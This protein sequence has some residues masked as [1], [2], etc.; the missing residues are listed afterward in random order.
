MVLV[1]LDI[2][3]RYQRVVFSVCL[4]VLRN[5]EDAEDIMQEVFVK[6]HKH[7]HSIRDENAIKA[8]LVHTAYNTAL[9]SL[10]YKP[11]LR[12]FSGDV[13]TDALPS[14]ELGPEKTLEIKEEFEKIDLWKKAKLSKKE[15]V[16]IQ[17]KLGEEM[18]FEEIADA[19][20]KSVSSIKTHYYRAMNK[21]KALEV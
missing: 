6:L 8:W 16:I 2:I 18:T 11:I 20:K 4:S 9:N 19:L 21:L 1:W 15:N 13:D 17:L 14:K 3:E 7:I 10:R 5:K 12:F